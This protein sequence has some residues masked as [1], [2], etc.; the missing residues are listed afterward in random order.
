M[1]KLNKSK[2]Y[3]LP[4]VDQTIDFKYVGDIV[5]T[6]ILDNE[7]K[8]QNLL[9]IKYNKTK[10]LLSDKEYIQSIIQN[11]LFISTHD[12]KNYIHFYLKIPIRFNREFELFRVGK[13][14]EFSEPAKQV[15][16]KFLLRHFQ[17]SYQTIELI[18]SILYREKQLRNQ[19]SKELN[20]YIPEDWELSSKINENMET[21]N[22]E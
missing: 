12:D 18:K 8:D 3:I 13:Y 15:I 17:S 14:S 21:F 1:E 22:Y 20:M 2:S 10:E 11:P 4:L 7:R 16:I 9:I 5:N 19:L 6:Y